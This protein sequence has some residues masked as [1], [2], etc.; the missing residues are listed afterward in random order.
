MSGERCPNCTWFD[1]RA[2][3]EL[4]TSPGRILCEACL[5]AKEASAES[6]G[7]FEPSDIPVQPDW[8]CEGCDNAQDAAPTLCTTCRLAERRSAFEAG[9]LAAIRADVAYA[10][11]QFEIAAVQ[12]AGDAG[13]HR[14]TADGASDPVTKEHHERYVAIALRDHAYWLTCQLDCRRWLEATR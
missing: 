7:D 9:R 12:A 10:A 4:G 6:T 2:R 8:V 14:R 3:G 1:V 13:M 5:A 11:G